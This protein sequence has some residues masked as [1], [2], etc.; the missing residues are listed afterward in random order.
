[1]RRL[2]ILSLVLVLVPL[3]CL[4]QDEEPEKTILIFPFKKVEDGK[5]AG[6]SP[7]LAAVLGAELSREGDVKI[8]QARPFA[9]IIQQSRIDPARMGRFARRVGAYAVMWGTVSKLREGYSVEVNVMTASPRAKPELFSRR[10]KRHGVAAGRHGGIGRTNRPEDPGSAT[11][12][13]DYGQ[14][15]SAYRDRYHHEPD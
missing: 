10:G 2:A 15:E 13:K 9:S 11:H 5:R 1:M 3:A 8:G 14:W 12:R 7:E 4:G 6:W